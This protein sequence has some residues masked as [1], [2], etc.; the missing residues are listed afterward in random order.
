MSCEAFFHKKKKNENVTLGLLYL[1]HILL[2]PIETVVPEMEGGYYNSPLSICCV[3]SPCIYT[4]IEY[5]MPNFLRIRS[6]EWLVGVIMSQ[7]L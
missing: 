6:S 7:Q 4:W 2:V 1:R 5:L 3:I